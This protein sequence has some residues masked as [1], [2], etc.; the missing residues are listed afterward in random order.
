MYHKEYLARGKT[1]FPAWVELLP[2]SKSIILDLFNIFLNFFSMMFGIGTKRS[3][4]HV[5][6]FVNMLGE[7]ELSWGLSHKGYIWSKGTS[8]QYTKPFRENVATTIG[9]YFDGVAGTL[10]Y[11]KDFEW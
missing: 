1:I 3:R 7:D 10:T 2:H 4:L 11:F 8:R 6:S 5:D 9:I